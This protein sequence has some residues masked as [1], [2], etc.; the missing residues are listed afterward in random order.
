MESDLRYE[1]LDTIASGE[2]A[3]VSR[4]RDRDLGREVAVKQIHPQYL[5]DPRQLAR[6]W[7]EAQLL[8]SLQHANILTI[9]DV[10][11][12]RGWL[13]LE[14]MRGSLRPAAEG[15]AM[16]L[17]QL[18]VV[19][20]NCLNGL[21]FLHR[22][23]VIHGDIKPSNI[24]VAPP[25]RIKLGDFGLARRA[26]NEEGSLLKGTTK[27]MAPE[28]L[29]AQFGAVG[30]A[31]D[32]YSLGFTAYELM[33]GAQFESLL[34]TLATF[35]R[36]KQLAWMMWHSTAD[37]KLPDI[38]RVLEGVPE[39]LAHVIQRLIAKDQSQRYRFAHEA[40]RDL[41]SSPGGGS[42]LPAPADLDAEAEAAEAI[43]RKKKVR[44]LALLAGGAA[45]MLC[46]LI[47]VMA[48]HHPKK[49]AVTHKPEIFHGKITDV[50]ASTKELGIAPLPEKIRGTVPGDFA[51]SK[52]I[53]V[54]PEDGG[55]ADR[56]PIDERDI[57]KVDG[58]RRT[59][60]SLNPGD[61]VE[62]TRATRR[63]AIKD[64]DI[65]YVNGERH[66]LEELE[67]GHDVVDYTRTVDPVSHKVV[68]E[69]HATRPGRF[70]TGELRARDDALRTI[71]ME[72]GDKGSP[73]EL[74]IFVPASLKKI[75]L[76]G[77]ATFHEKPVT[78][79]TLNLGDRL[80]VQYD[81][82]E[83]TGNNIANKLEALRQVELEGVLA[84]DFDGRALSVVKDDKQVVKLPFGSQY[85]IT[86]NGQ[87]VAKPSS[88]KRG[89][90][91]TVKH[92]MYVAEVVARRRLA[93]EGVVQQI[94]YESCTLNVAADSGQ[95][96]TYVAG[97]T[98]KIF[99]GD[100]AV[101][102]DKLRP[103]DRVKIEH[104]AVDA[105]NQSPI[106]ATSVTAERPTDAT[107]WAMIIAVQNYD[108]K[109][110]SPLSYPLADATLV[111]DVLTKRYRTPPEQLRLF[112]DPS[113]V[114]LER[115]I[116]DFLKK[117]GADGRL[118]VY[119]VGHACKDAEG[120]VYLAPKDFH[121][122]QPAV[123]GRP[124]Q[125]LVDLL[126]DCPAKEKL[127][128]LDGSHAGTGAEQAVE[129]SSAEMILALKMQPNRARLRKVT[130]VASCRKG[131][132]GIDLADKEH[133]LFAWCL[134]EGY[135]GAADV[136]RDTL[137]EPTE[138]YAYLQKQMPATGGQGEQLPALFLPD[139]R[140]PRLNEAAKTSI[141]KLAGYVDQVKV[142]LDEASQEYDTALQA[143]G[144]EPE[145]RLLYGLV[146]LKK[147]DRE[148]ALQHFE[149]VKGEL[150]D[151]LLP[152]AAL[153]WLKMDKR[154]YP[155]AIHELTELINKIPKTAR[156]SALVPDPYE[157][158][159]QLRDFAAGQGRSSLLLND[160][161][162]ALDAAVAAR[163]PQA[164]ALYAKGR[165][166]SAGILDDFDKKIEQSADDAE[167]GT[168]A[169][170]RKQLANYADFPINAYKEQVLAH[171][172]E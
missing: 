142:N 32:L 19:L 171:L 99:L 116:P 17:D 106:G 169:I 124:L 1:I 24:L 160:A 158:A 27:Y 154:A 151:R 26:S 100:E 75:L 150:P 63:I 131:Q 3:T 165:Q 95:K 72:A 109:Q 82:D 153:G 69:I 117:V 52:Q 94:G 104:E 112:S 2:F 60:Q 149:A 84:E 83:A 13:I 97:P 25:N 146:L 16:D 61:V 55:T 37:V 105:K 23:G 41:Q 110:L 28:L 81:Y 7:Q 86:V 22:N 107:R 134:A 14:L 33:V 68:Q 9:Y 167:K 93:A 90:Q 35:G 59:P 121:V 45:V 65:I 5:A 64:Q 115:E 70:A 50:L 18:R 118:I 10:V 139:D 156:S 144:T 129:P 155:A 120:Q 148:K 44:T 88:L 133:G 78:L 125:W 152:Y 76:N 87:P 143:A 39:D 162:S 11:R 89:D 40:L 6:Y 163:G 34:P 111:S 161:V 73:Q 103:G 57:I 53:E 8:A 46:V 145:P 128:L 36:N 15:D 49:V 114:T 47:L 113:A 91:V 92:D 29:S 122:D 31:S 138:L 102:L 147:K 164:A 108:D 170:N 21:D 66:L 172:D 119:F 136:N 38:Q 77:K 130:A 85:V 43:R 62:V 123:N 157:W 141:R 96:W 79:T 74:K 135:G 54:V 30:P 20:A 51:T 48:L 56:I 98:C 140:P 80:K 159:G 4:A 42:G 137:V 58:Q 101:A 166:H 127:L 71:V 12:P 67:A 168:L 126:E 132:H